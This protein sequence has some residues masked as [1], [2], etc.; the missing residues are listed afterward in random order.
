MRLG[1]CTVSTIWDRLFISRQETR[2]RF[3]ASGGRCSKG[4]GPACWTFC[5]GYLTLC[6]LHGQ[7]QATHNPQPVLSEGGTDP[8]PMVAH[9]HLEHGLV[10]SVQRE[11]PSSLGVNRDIR[12]AAGSQNRG[13][14]HMSGP[15]P[16]PLLPGTVRVPSQTTGGFL[17]RVPHIL[18]CLHLFFSPTL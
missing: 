13:P 17:G 3:R 16:R 6:S 5:P 15:D 14:D 10:W 18:L 1:P 2:P 4:G 7:P 12:P 9:K 8:P 11:V